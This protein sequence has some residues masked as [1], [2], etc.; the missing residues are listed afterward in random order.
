MTMIEIEERKLEPRQSVGE[1]SSA[2]FVRLACAAAAPIYK[3]HHSSYIYIY[4]ELTLT[5]TTTRA[6]DQKEGKQNFSPPC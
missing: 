4:I 2:E 1:D 5:L 6:P 3:I